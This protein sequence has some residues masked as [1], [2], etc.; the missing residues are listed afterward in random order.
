M[1][2]PSTLECRKK[3]DMGL[4]GRHSE[5]LSVGNWYG[6]ATYCDHNEPSFPYGQNRGKENRL[7]L[8]LCLNRNGQAKMFP[9]DILGFNI[10]HALTY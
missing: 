3:K 2:L 4:Q 7:W 10:S 9:E 1:P 6:S 8:Y 5:K